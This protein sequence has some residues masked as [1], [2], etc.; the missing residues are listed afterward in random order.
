MYIILK[1]Y[2]D[3]KDYEEIENLRKLCLEADKTT[4]KLEL[5]Y[6]LAMSDIGGETRNL[7]EFMCY[8]GEMLVGYAGI[9]HF[10][11]DSMEVNGMVH[12]EYRRRG[13]FKRLFS[14]VKNEWNKR[15]IPGLL[16]LSDHNSPSGLGF[17]ASEEALHDHSEYEMYLRGN[18]GGT[19]KTSRIILRKAT[20]RDALE[21]ARQNSVYFGKE[22]GEE[23]I[24]MPEDEEK[25]GLHIY[26]A[27]LDGQVIGKVH[28]ETGKAINGIYGL[29]VL[30]DYRGMGYGR[31]ILSRA[32]ELMKE[33]KAQ[34]I[35]LQV[36]ATNSNAL[37][38]Y[39]SCGFEE[40]STMDYYRLCK[41]RD[42]SASEALL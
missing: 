28:L 31:E 10:G 36:V 29:G 35:M 23:D 14:L 6:K 40:T 18:M 2:L 5:E 1:E 34:E 41:A 8:S 37:N 24:R 19:P 30:P 3:R 21:I 22:L 20:N 38:L 32:V 25:C 27:E 13:I 39:R 17:I 11:G 16:M 15:E 33:A 9:C 12:P 4:L 7:N 42:R 26:I